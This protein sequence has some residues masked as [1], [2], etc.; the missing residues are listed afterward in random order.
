M[1]DNPQIVQYVNIALENGYGHLEN[2]IQNDLVG[3]MQSLLLTLTSS[4]YSVLR[5]LINMVIG[6]VVAIYALWA[7]DRFLC[8]AKKLTVALW[9][10]ERADR[11]MEQARKVDKIF[12][13]FIIGKIIDSLII[14]VLCY[15]R[16]IHSETALRRAG[17]HHCGR[18][19]CDSVFRPIIGAIPCTLLI[20]LNSPLQG[21]YFV[22]FVL[23]LQ[24][25]DGNI[26]GPKILGDNVGISGFWILVSITVGGGLFG[27]PGMLLGVP[28]FATLYMLIS[29]YTERA[30]RKQGKPIQTK[31]YFSIRQVA[32]LPAGETE[33]KRR[34]GTLRVNLNERS[35]DI[36]NEAG[37]LHQCGA[38]IAPLLRGKRCFVVSDTNV[39]PLYGDTV[40]HSLADAGLEA[41]LLTIPAGER[42]KDAGNAGL[43]LGADGP[44]WCHP[45]RHCHCPGWRRGGRF[46]GLCRRHH[47]AGRGFYPDS[48]TLLPRWIP[49][50]AVWWLWIWWLVKSGR[51]LLPAQT[52]AD[53]PGD[54]DHTAGPSLCRRHGGGHQ[55]RLYL[56]RSI[57]RKAGNAWARPVRL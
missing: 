44:G 9:S 53:G 24:Q 35:Y 39:A 48:T 25:I 20:L 10:P 6:I 31:A 51:S 29:D 15:Y 17:V 27:F 11:F 22:I 23:V 45:H 42:S 18:H 7:K 52:G 4:V 56:G 38:Y 36:V 5:E 1:E 41:T 21:L 50:W 43:A 14:G 3:R 33:R 49:P 26:I 55:I 30:L 19:Q 40:L 34:M 28:V 32:D 13:G 16:R 47:A 8:Q 37:V 12:N 2:F 46:G 54:A 57:V